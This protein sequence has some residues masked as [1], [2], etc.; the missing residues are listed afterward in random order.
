MSKVSF[1]E[2]SSEFAKNLELD[3]QQYLEIPLNHLPEYDSLGKISTSVMIE[4]LF[5]FQITY[6]FLEKQETLQ[7]LYDYCVSQSLEE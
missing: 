3:D 1:E 7:S 2:F 5:G 6:K 4:E